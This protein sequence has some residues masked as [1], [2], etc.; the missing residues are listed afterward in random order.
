MGLQKVV[1]IILEGFVRKTLYPPLLFGIV[2][3]FLSGHLSRMVDFSRLLSI[4][5]PRGF[6][7][8]THLLYA[9]DVMI[10]CKDTVQNLKNI[11]RAFEVYGKISDQL[12][13]WGKSSIYFGSSVSSSWIGRL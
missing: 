4:S 3:D 13:N 5:S 10:F 1:F 7:A 8:P 9:C 11:L 12:V 2:E 6:S